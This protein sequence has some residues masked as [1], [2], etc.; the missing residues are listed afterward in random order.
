MPARVEDRLKLLGVE[1]ARGVAAVMVVLLHASGL[2]AG[3]KD[4]GYNPFGNFWQFGRAGVDFFFVLSGFIISYVH[5]DDLGRPSAFWSFWRKRVLRI[6]PPYWIVLAVFGAILAFS[7]THDG[8]ERHP[9]HIL[10]SILLLPDD[11]QAPILGV[12]WS[13][14]HEIVFYGVFSLAILNRTIGLAALAVWFTL[15]V[16]NQAVVVGTGHPFFAGM[17]DNTFFRVF[18]IQFLFG[19]AV[20]VAFRRGPAPWPRTMLIV[21]TILFFA[22]GMV[23]S[24]GPA[25]P[26]EWPPRHVAYALGGALA[27]YGLATLDQQRAIRVPPVMLL[28]GRCSYSIYLVHTVVLLLLQQALRR[29][30]PVLDLGPGLT[31]IV[32]VTIAVCVGIVFSLTIERPLLRTGNRL[33]LSGRTVA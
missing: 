11:W 20:A 1:A 28:L 27:L 19:I 6:Y 3:P 24:F 13:L 30:R 9:V 12:A 18:N 26:V 25:V 8:A 32:C 21:G 10:A 23:E 5:A 29:A 15:I 33:L 7:P 22:N 2:M 17:L 14:R 16:F 31:Y 4:Y